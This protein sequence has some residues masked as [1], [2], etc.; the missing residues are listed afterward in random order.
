MDS[1]TDRKVLETNGEKTGVQKLNGEGA[2][3]YKIIYLN[4]KSKG[5]SRKAQVKVKKRCVSRESNVIS[6]INK[7]AMPNKSTPHIENS[8]NTL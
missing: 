6:E 2:S 3:S 5:T 7:E 1:T 4:L 8:I